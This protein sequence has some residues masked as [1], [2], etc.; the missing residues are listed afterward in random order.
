MAFEAKKLTFFLLK[1]LFIKFIQIS[2]TRTNKSYLNQPSNFDLKG[3]SS[4]FSIMKNLLFFECLQPE[5]KI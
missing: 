4:S 1:N 3:N 2:N 5:K